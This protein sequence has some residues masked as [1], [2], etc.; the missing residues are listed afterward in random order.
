MNLAVE[1]STPGTVDVAERRDCDPPDEARYDSTKLV[2][3]YVKGVEL[4]ASY[5]PDPD[6]EDKAFWGGERLFTLRIGTYHVDNDETQRAFHAHLS[7][8]MTRQ[9]AEALRDGLAFFIAQDMR[10]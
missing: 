9:E 2:D 10:A 7:V 3:A 6:D 8:A 1:F 5:D 4:W